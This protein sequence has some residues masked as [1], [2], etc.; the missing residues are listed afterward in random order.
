MPPK[1]VFLD[2]P[3]GSGKSTKLLNDC[4]S[5]PAPW[6]IATF[7]KDAAAH[8]V[9]RGV[10]RSQ[11]GTIYSLSWPHASEFSTGRRS[12]DKQPAWQRRKL[13]DGSDQ[14]LVHYESTAP[15]KQKPIEALPRLHAWHPGTGESLSF[16][17]GKDLGKSGSFVLPLARWLEAGAPWAEGFEGY[18]FLAVDE[19]QDMGAL[20]LSACLA[21]MKPGGTVL[22]VGDPGQSIFAAAKGI[23]AG[24]LP[25]AYAWAEE[26][27][28]LAQGFRVGYP[29]SRAAANVLSPY[30]ERPAD[31][32]TADH[33]TAVSI[34]NGV[35]PTEG[36]VLGMSRYGVANWV[37]ANDVRDYAVSPQ[38]AARDLT[39]C[40][41]H[42]AKGAE[43]DD[44]YLLPWGDKKLSLLRD[45]DPNL[46]RLLYVASTRARKRLHAPAELFN[47]LTKNLI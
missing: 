29:C 44:V 17:E 18:E 33:T 47:L 12:K 31:T 37:R 41:I 40:T 15:S 8:L 30:Y 34:W 28:T 38:V 16:L 1:L 36:L 5:W 24:E 42:A 19:A 10:R 22:A 43:A 7:S 35:P 45:E 23:M 39:V 26:R 14:A 13:Q 27:E 11:A 21:L 32:F 6:A 2:G 3:P 20:E 9:N 46:L 4:E 25:P